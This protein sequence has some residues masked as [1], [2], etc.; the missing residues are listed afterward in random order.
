MREGGIVHARQI[1]RLRAPSDRRLQV[2]ALRLGAY[3]RWLLLAWFA[4]QI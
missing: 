3:I 4:S 1:L 2:L